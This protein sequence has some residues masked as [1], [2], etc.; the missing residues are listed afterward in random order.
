[1]ENLYKKLQEDQ[2]EVR[3]RLVEYMMRRGYNQKDLSKILT[4]S[5]QPLSKFLTQGKNLRFPELCKI[6]SHLEKEIVRK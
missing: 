2:S 1:M 3:N 5:K 4:I 6:T